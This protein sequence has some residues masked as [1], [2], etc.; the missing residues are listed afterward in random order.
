MQSV[1]DKSASQK[2]SVDDARRN[3]S[4]NGPFTPSRTQTSL[5][6]PYFDILVMNR[7]VWWLL[8]RRCV[9][10]SMHAVG[11]ACCVRRFFFSH[12]VLTSRTTYYYYFGISI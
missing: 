8:L 5:V 11:S 2:G 3:A 9:K 10:K 4:L 7:T 6:H 1:R 12:S